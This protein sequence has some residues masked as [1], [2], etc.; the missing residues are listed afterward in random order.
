MN[1]LERLFLDRST[2]CLY[3]NTID[4]YRL[5]LHNPKTLIEELIIV[6]NDSIQGV[7]TNNDYV[8]ATS[9]E[10]K[11][12][13]K[14]KNHS[15]TFLGINEN[16]FIKLLDKP[17][18]T[19]YKIIQQSCKIILKHNN[20][21]QKKIIDEI[22]LILNSYIKYIDRKTCEISESCKN[23]YR[24]IREKLLCLTDFLFIE[25]INNNFSK[26]YLYKTI[27]SIFIYHKKQNTNFDIQFNIFR[28][29]I[30]KKDETYKVIFTIED[31]TFDF[32]EFKKIN[33]NYFLI[34]PIFRNKHR[35][36]LSSTG[37]NYLEKNKNNLQI[38]LE[39]TTKD[40]YKATQL[41]ID[42]FSKDLDIFHLAFSNKAYPIN[43]HCLVIGDKKPS[44]ANTVPINYQIDGYFK[45][46]ISIFNYIIDKINAISNSNMEKDSYQKIL[47]A[48]RYYRTGSESPELETK[49]LNYWIGLEFIF[50]SFSDDEK[51]ITR[52]RKYFTNSHSLIYVKR[53][54][55][56]FHKTI[57][58]LRIN[59]FIQ[60]YD[61]NLKYLLHNSTYDI[62]I[63]KSESEL[64]KQRALYFQKWFQEP[65]K[66]TDAINK[67]KENLTWN[68]TRLYRIRNEIVHNA[69]IK[70]DIYSHISHLKYYL[71]FIL[72][73]IMD[74]M[75]E[76][77]PDLDNDGKITIDDFLICQDILLGAN[78]GEK[79][80]KWLELKH[81]N[82][83]FQ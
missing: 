19:N 55:Y 71:T 39:I 76:P 69:A 48:I 1:N 2:E 5:K 73:S 27:Q 83:I 75:S 7:L 51:T 64:L 43:A 77:Y 44:R 63:N 74:F 60:E 15:L 62:I 82:Q 22:S 81:P 20:N 12:I 61:N 72:N 38:G 45:S 18:P 25:L 9:K 11:R 17:A 54:M 30:N 4:T 68:I 28:K 29:I 41:S 49:F 33:N 31:H 34:D 56:D 65:N 47:S 53:N 50:N 23:E 40:H 37:N 66:I 6:I 24:E 46:N 26:Q 14:T 80:G 3:F 42:Q 78:T 16:H 79:L 59:H 21:Y 57:K 52:I 32:N 70:K 10:L 67:H 35:N 8:E 58:R 13:L 36:E